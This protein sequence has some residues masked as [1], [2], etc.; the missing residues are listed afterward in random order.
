MTNRSAA[1][2]R[3]APVPPPPPP[4][5]RPRILAIAFGAV[6]VVTAIGVA[7]ALAGGGSSSS[8]ASAIEFGTVGIDG[9]PLAAFASSGADPMIG[10]PAPVLTGQAV[11]GAPVTV[12][13]AGEPTIVAFLAHWCPHCQAELP[14]LV[15][16]SEA[17]GFDGVRMVAVLTGTNPVAPNFPP[18]EWLEREGWTGDVVVDDEASSAAAAY[19]LAGYPF[20]VALDA[21]GNVVERTSGELPADRVED[22]AAAA[23]GERP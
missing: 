18:A 23:R 10:A 12:G 21:A 5:R 4:A 1:T 14:V 16:V 6:A 15:E 20:L 3:R 13:G 8:D 2:A 7:V 19:G 17:G 11:D 22:L 9:T